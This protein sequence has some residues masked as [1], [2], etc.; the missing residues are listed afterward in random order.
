MSSNKGPVNGFERVATL[1]PELEKQ[2][3]TKETR[4]NGETYQQNQTN[5]ETDRQNQSNKAEKNID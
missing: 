5:I 2:D 4:T 3:D 1:H